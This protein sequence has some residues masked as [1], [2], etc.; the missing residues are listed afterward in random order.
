MWGGETVLV[1][2]Y[3]SD[4]ERTDCSRNNV[5]MLADTPIQPAAPEST[6]EPIREPDVERTDEATNMQDHTC[7]RPVAPAIT[8]SRG[9]R[10]CP[11]KWSEDYAMGPQA[12]TATTP[13]TTMRM[14]DHTTLAEAYG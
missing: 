1:E 5:V 9:R 12:S 7:T 14:P 2:I 3:E 13:H 10:L 4:D 11:P 8:S 6:G